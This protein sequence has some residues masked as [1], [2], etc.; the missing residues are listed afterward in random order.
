[1]DADGLVEFERHRPRL[2]ALAYR[3]MGSAAEAEDAVQETYLRWDTSDRTGIRSAEAWL[4]TILVN[5]CRSWLDSARARR[6]AYV[7]PWLPEP[8]PTGRG[9][10]GPLES[11]EQRELVSIAFLTLAERLSP[12]ERAVFV[13]R[14]AFGY[15][16]REIA[17]MLDLTEANAQQV[18]RRATHRVHEERP[19]FEPAPAHA[20][21]L[22]EK[23]LDAAQ[24]GDLAALEAMFT[25]D[26]VAVA[27]GGTRINAAKV[28]IV[29]AAKVARYLVGLFTK[30]PGVDFA[31][32]EVN[33]APAFVAR[34]RGTV[35][36]IVSA[37]FDGGS[38]DSVRLMV[39]PDK[40]VYFGR[41][42]RALAD[43]AAG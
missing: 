10:L 13:L 21:E 2:F 15:A 36:G 32:E 37:G 39:N 19:R 1:M 30:V 33:G 6:E 11:A 9:E 35:M 29:G 22:V 5:L 8:V 16:H 18:Y 40:L 25:A 24:S 34:L 43:K 23:F 42:D 3:M 28:P 4:T 27:D 20:R 31:I 14:E 26:I 41:G 7:G 38:I 12:T 17:D